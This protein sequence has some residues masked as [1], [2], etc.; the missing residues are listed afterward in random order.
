MKS[1]L[2]LFF[3]FLHHICLGQILNG[4]FEEW[5]ANPNAGTEESK[6][7]LNDWQHCDQSGN[8]K[9][10]P[11]LPGTYRD[12]LPHS[13]LFALTLSRWYSIDY[14]VVKFKNACPSKPTVLHGYYKYSES[15]LHIGITDTAQV[16]VFLTKF[17]AATQKNDTIGSGILDLATAHNFTQFQCLIK[18]AQ[19]NSFP[20]SITIVIQPTKF[21]FG[22]GG[23]PTIPW[24][25]Y[26]TVDDISL[27]SVSGATEPTN[28]KPYTVFPNPT[29]SGLTVSGD[30][31][32]ERLTLFNALGELV[33]DRVA[34]SNK[35]FLDTSGLTGGL[36]FLRIKG[37]TE[38]LIMA[39]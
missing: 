24:C 4:S 15:I 23:C 17:N 7:T 32:N 11:S 19:P 35:E 2:L 37:K 34:T 5:T 9:E 13:G 27:S 28:E 20:D 6:W 30:I 26:L 8:Q 10:F 14:D 21:R 33:Y 16:S 29:T 36:Y 12:S 31:L 18:Y 38:K 39:Q 25:S 1:T 3:L 22:V